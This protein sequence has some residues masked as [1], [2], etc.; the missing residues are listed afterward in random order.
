MTWALVQTGNSGNTYWNGGS[1]VAAAATFP[2]P[3][4]SGSYIIGHWTNDL[5]GGDVL[6]VTDDQGNTYNLGTRF[7]ITGDSQAHGWF[8]LPNVTNAPQT[9]SV[10]FNGNA[11]V[12]VECWEVSGL[13]N[14]PPDVVNGLWQ[15]S[16]GS[17]TD[18]VFSDA[19]GTA[20]AANN[21]I[22][23]GFWLSDRG[24]DNRP[25]APGSSWDLRSQV[26]DEPTQLAGTVILATETQDIVA[27]GTLARA[28]YTADNGTGEYSTI[29]VTLK[30]SG[31]T[32]TQL[33]GAS[34]VTRMTGSI[35]AIGDAAISG[36]SQ[37]QSKAVAVTP[38]VH[39]GAVSNV[40]RYSGSGDATGVL[41]VAARSQSASQA[42]GFFGYPIFISARS[43][44][45]MTDKAA[46]AGVLGITASAQSQSKGSAS[47]RGTI[48]ISG[49]ATSQSKAQPG[50]A[51]VTFL[52]TS[53]R[54]ASMSK[55][56]GGM[57]AR[58]GIG[59]R[60]LIWMADKG[61]GS[62]NLLVALAARSVSQAKGRAGFASGNQR[63]AL[64][65][66]SLS[67]Y[68]ARAGAIGA[69]TITGRTL[70]WMAD[71]ARGAGA[72]PLAARATSQAKGKANIG[73][74]APITAAMRGR[75]TSQ[76]KGRGTLTGV[77]RISAMST[78]QA[79]G[80]PALRA[81]ALIG[82]R[83]AAQAKGRASILT[84][85]QMRARSASASKGRASFVMGSGIGGRSFTKASG[86]I[87]GILTAPLFGHTQSQS[88]GR[89]GIA[90]AVPIKAMAGRSA[91]QVKTRRALLGSTAPYFPPYYPPISP[92]VMPFEPFD[93]IIA[94]Y[95]IAMTWER[96]HQ[97]PCIYGN[98]GMTGSPDP[99]CET[100]H[101]LGWYWE[102]PFG[103]FQ[104]LITFIRLNPS[105]DEPGALMNEK[106]GVEIRQEPTVTIP[107]SA[108]LVW[109]QASVMDRFVE[110]DA[111][112]RFQTKLIKGG[113]VD[114][115]YQHQLTV[116]PTGAVTIYDEVN[117]EVIIVPD[118]TVNGTTVSIPD[119]YPEGTAYTVEFTAAKTYI[120]W[121]NAGSVPHDRP[122][123]QVTEPKRFRFQTLDLWL[124]NKG[125]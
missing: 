98:F 59:G 104:G 83:T 85:I 2:A 4:T 107:F 34:L 108:G 35:V 66:R 111:I 49:R 41:A 57:S 89:A 38:N 103:P 60:T 56:K 117:H 31:A 7:D 105:P 32:V 76:S 61:V 110:V 78:S 43:F 100:C 6:S 39:L 28:T 106:W 55:G 9:I 115:P 26:T 120:A 48:R 46:G 68:T 65:G 99:V 73:G 97:C 16:P 63:L 67:Q 113:I 54:S 33:E 87:Q 11:Y 20:T 79:K 121:R 30:V 123:G 109:E 69:V 118:Y 72:S 84:G 10:N 74:A 47:P 62:Q 44:L 82:A 24:V 91:S 71:K 94:R 50:I 5:G 64:G 86:K 21:E 119:S 23:F 15:S 19:T 95:G 80:V 29:C 45:R 36:R 114:I 51:T 27:S 25:I 90:G 52:Q 58:A 77:L 112:D 40:G 125:G 14:D 13:T 124:R 102:E 12:M 8:W 3:V 88:K 42:I 70:M 101:G 37:S 18:A 96:S 17:G 75:A 1:A 22:A 122:F 116:Q 53:G 93:A 81:L 92:Y